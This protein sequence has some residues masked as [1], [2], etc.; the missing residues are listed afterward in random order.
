M[1]TLSNI[2]I[3]LI[4]F[5]L[6]G[7]LHSQTGLDV[8]PPRNYYTSA[9]GESTVNKINVSNPSKSNSLTLT[10]SVNDWEYDSS[11][12]NVIAEPGT[13]KNSAAKWISIKPQS[14]F[15]LAPGESQQVEITVTPPVKR[16]DSLNV[17]TALVFVTQTNPV[18]SYNEKGALIKISLRSGVKIYHRFDEKNS[19]GVEFT[20]YKFNK[21]SR[22][23]ELSIGNVGN[24]WTDGTVVTELVDQNDGTQVK[25]QDQIIYTLPGDERVVGIPLPAVLKQGKYI[26]TST[27]SYGDDDTIKMAE[28]TFIY[29]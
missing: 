21:K 14:Y 9:P 3:V 29:D 19:P 20:D 8:T 25:L 4:Q 15:T 10:V 5:C 16:F 1:K 26:A 7:F 11:G 12:N 13:L 18:D 24:T 17:H 6:G 22:K 23:L 27:F 28:L 2:F